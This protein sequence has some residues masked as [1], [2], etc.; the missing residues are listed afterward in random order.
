MSCNNAM[1]INNMSDTWDASGIQKYAIKMNVNDIDSLETSKLLS[2]LVTD[3]EKFAIDKY[4]NIFQTTTGNGGPTT[5][6]Y[7]N[8]G[9]WGVHVDLQNDYRYLAYNNG[10]T[11]DNLRFGLTGGTGVAAIEILNEGSSLTSSVSSIDFVG[12]G[13]TATNVGDVV[14]VT[15][16]TLQGEQGPSGLQGEQGPSG[17][18]G[19]QGPSGVSADPLIVLYEG[20]VIDSSATGIHFTGNG[21]SVT[22]VD[23]VVIVDIVSTGVFDPLETHT[24]G[25]QQ[26]D[27]VP[28]TYEAVI[29]ITGNSPSQTTTLT[30]DQTLS[31]TGTIPTSKDRVYYAEISHTGNNLTISS[32]YDPGGYFS[33]PAYS[34]FILAFKLTSSGVPRY[35]GVI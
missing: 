4:G 21:V 8:S 22:S 6:E 2:L 23:D 27:W 29:D 19:D 18:Q 13:V 30:S 16:N 25:V 31:F 20:S 32:T 15:I 11:V 12:S 3:V 34:P 33:Q 5:T 1:V 10:T 35:A 26:Y 17:L 9:T 28:M 14:M 24:F 7:P